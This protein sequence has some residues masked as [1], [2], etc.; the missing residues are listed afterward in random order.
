MKIYNLYSTY[1]E[2]LISNG[3]IGL[4]LMVFYSLLLNRIKDLHIKYIS[5]AIGLL[6]FFIALSGDIF[7]FYGIMLLFGWFVSVV[8]LQINFD[9]QEDNYER[10]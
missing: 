6:I 1:I 4:F 8:I 2:I 3:L 5:Y 10:I 7:F 9:Q